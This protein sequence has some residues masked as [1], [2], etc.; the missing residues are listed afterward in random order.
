VLVKWDNTADTWQRLSCAGQELPEPRS[1]HS[2]ERIGDY[3]YFFGGYNEGCC[4]SDL[5][6]FDL[7]TYQWQP[8][9]TRTGSPAPEG[10]ASHAACSLHTSD[11][12]GLYYIHGGSGAE[13]GRSS[14]ND[15]WCYSTKKRSWAQLRQKGRVPPAM[16]G[17]TMALYGA[18]TIILFGGTTGWDYFNDVYAFDIRS[19]TWRT[20]EVRG[21][22][23]STRYKHQCCII[24]DGLYILGGGQFHAPD[25]P[26]DVHRLDLVTL[27]WE[28]IVAPNA[29]PGRLAHACAVAVGHPS[30][31]Q[32]RKPEAVEDSETKRRKW[33]R[34][35]KGVRAA[36]GSGRLDTTS[37]ERGDIKAFLHDQHLG[38]AGEA[39]VLVE[40]RASS[41]SD[42]DACDA[43]GA[44]HAAEA[45]AE[46]EEEVDDSGDSDFILVFGG[47]DNRD[48]KLQ[49]M[50]SFDVHARVWRCMSGPRE[51][52]SSG[53]RARAVAE[54]KMD[55][56]DFHCMEVVQNHV[57]VFAGCAGDERLDDVWRYTMRRGPPSLQM[58]CARA[59][60]KQI[61]LR[62]QWD[63]LDA[64]PEDLQLAIDNLTPQSEDL[65]FAAAESSDGE[66]ESESEDTK[67]DTTS[68]KMMIVD[69][70]EG[71]HGWDSEA[72]SHTMQ[73][74]HN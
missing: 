67:S 14:K 63:L 57:F 42:D 52:S 54:A 5:Y 4:M 25:Y 70:L 8:L 68:V 7:R 34:R 58:L 69:G 64:M 45:Y 55:P 15:L 13:W 35:L 9:P 11:K 48:R 3:C 6:R 37:P 27:T 38:K 2:V 20:L 56:R 33:H 36:S 51:E 21:T 1:G 72:P 16:Y 61:E 44:C 66:E 50:Y 28:Q 40:S 41:F 47:K 17:H 74:P 31:F 22:P 23:P 24:K 59:I 10:R 53:D 26:F 19:G 43:A 65:E 60:R 32:F 71:H 30:Q 62:E 29:P 18:H 12:H 39:M 46:S 73:Q 49:D